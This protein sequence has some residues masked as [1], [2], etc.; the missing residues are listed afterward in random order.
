LAAVEAGLAALTGSEEDHLIVRLCAIALR[1]FADHGGSPPGAAASRREPADYL[2]LAEKAVAMLAERGTPFP[3]AQANLAVA[4]AENARGEAH[5]EPALWR[6]SVERWTGLAQ[7]YPGVYARYRLAEA[8]NATAK[9]RLEAAEM[10]AAAHQEATALGAAPLAAEIEAFRQRAN[11]HKIA[12]SNEGA[13]LDKVAEKLAPYKLT[14]R[15]RQVLELLVA[16]LS[17]RLIG[18]RLEMTEKTASVHVSNVIRK[19]EVTNRTQAATRGRAV[20][21]EG[22]S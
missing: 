18:R 5:P 13:P 8:L 1:G 3:E 9:T 22:Q 4:R 19:L 7:P 14:P 2:G 12:P 17:N 6:A 15:E 10:S 21:I 16:G 20:G 11:L